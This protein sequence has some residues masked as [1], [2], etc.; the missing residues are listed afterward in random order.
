MN[1]LS[2]PLRSVFFTIVALNC[3]VT[4]VFGQMPGQSGAQDVW[5]YSGTYAGLPSPSSERRCVVATS[6]GVY[7][8]T[9]YGSQMYIE[10][11]D[12]SGAFVSKFSRAFTRLVGLASNSGGDIYGFDGATGIGYCF[13]SSGTE[14]FSF[15]TGT[16]SSNGKFN[17]TYRDD[18][19]HTVAVNSQGLIYVTDFSNYRVQ[20]FNA[21]GSFKGTFGQYGSLPGQ[22]PNYTAHVAVGPQ[23]T[24]LVIDWSAN[25]TKFTASG[26]YISKAPSTDYHWWNKAFS[27]SSDGQLLVGMQYGYQY[28]G[29]PAPTAVLVDLNTMN[30]D[31]WRSLGWADGA[32]LGSAT[33]SNAISGDFGY[34]H[35][36][37]FDPAGNVWM[38]RYNSVTPSA[39]SLERFERRMRFDNHKPSKPVPLPTVVSTLQ[40]AGS[41]TVDICYRVD[42]PWVTSGTLVN[43]TLMGGSL[44]SGGSVSTALVGWL[45]G[46]KNWSH[47][48]VPSVG[49]GTFAASGA[50]FWSDLYD[51]STRIDNRYP[52]QSAIRCSAVDGS[53][54]VYTVTDYCIR[55]TSPSGN[56]TTL[57]GLAG[58]SSYVD[59]VGTTARFQNPFGICVDRD[60]NV[61]VVEWDGHVVRKITPSGVVTTIA[62]QWGQSGS[63]DARGSAARFYYPTK[64]AVDSNGV[65]YVAEYHGQRV[66]RV[67]QDGT[68]STLASGLGYPDG[69]TVDS[70]GNVFVG[71]V[72]GSGKILKLSPGA[73]SPVVFA[74]TQATGYV[75]ATGSAARL[76]NPRG[77]CIDGLDNIFFWDEGSQKVRKVTPEGQVSTIGQTLGNASVCV[78]ALGCVYVTEGSETAGLGRMIRKGSPST[79]TTRG[80]SAPD[81]V[82][83]D[84]IQTGTLKTVSWD[85]SKDLPG[86]T[87]ASL[88]FEVLAKDDRPALG[89]HFVTIPGD[90]SNPNNSSDLKISN[91]PID[92]A[93]LTDLWVWLLANHDPRI[94]VSGNSIVLT[95]AG[96]DYLANAPSIH[97]ASAADNSTMTV[98]TGGPGGLN[99]SWDSNWW[100]STTN[101]GRAFACKLMNY[102]PVTAAEVTRANAGRYNLSSANHY[103]VVKLGQ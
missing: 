41:Q 16:G 51:P 3:L 50:Y 43:G 11:Y 58:Y 17:G 102:R 25:L 63:T 103:S 6:D 27:V 30:S 20:I 88:S 62:G 33:F 49:S 54:N 35:G 8:G 66:R 12:N 29:W 100:G 15:G 71:L 99:G 46:V 28:W 22:F 59:D 78:D 90:A 39:W 14:K 70:A 79:A 31:Y 36:A 94:T 10:K 26:E 68:V 84:G 67:T 23:D 55:K 61:Y 53:G 9:F 96:L 24:V 52:L 2:L 69:I 32:L 34:V 80:I 60:S 42:M 65:L 48:V 38:I 76:Y 21:D 98:H 19:Y 81:G 86:M 1:T 44:T 45:G 5:N 97:D 75:D 83:G 7:V 85:V 92:E 101:R 82:L 74:G 64:I 95:Q 47:L 72:E 77:L 57:A 13:T 91:R 87:F 37:S 40:Q 4:A 89:A 18:I 73:S 56:V 93:D